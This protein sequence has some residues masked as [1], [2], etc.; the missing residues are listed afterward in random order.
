MTENSAER[1]G[2]NIN[3]NKQDF[4]TPKLRN[5]LFGDE[6]SKKKLEDISTIVMGQSPSSSNYSN[7]SDE[8]VL[9]QGNQDLQNGYIIPRIYTSQIT[10]LSKPGD[11]I[12]T[13]RAPVGDIAINEYISCI[14]R[15]VCSITPKEDKKFIYY[16]LQFLNNKNIWN[17]YSQGSTFESVNSKDIKNL[18]INIPTL[19]EQKYISEFFSLIDQKI[20]FMEKKYNVLDK[21]H[22]S[23]I[24]A[25]LNN[26][27]NNEEYKKISL[28]HIVNYTSSNLSLN[29]LEDNCGS[30]PLFG[31]DGFVKNIDF[32][33]MGEEYIGIVKDGAGVGRISYN[34]KKTSVLGT[35][36]Y[37]T[38]KGNINLKYVYYYLNMLNLSKYIVGSTI[39]HIY[40]KDYSKEK[41]NLPQLIEQEKIVN[42]LDSVNELIINLNKEIEI[43]RDFKKSLLTKMFC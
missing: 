33:E 8:T 27:M 41:I 17:K 28:N 42:L 15:G 20:S 16:Y 1:S 43:N 6:W 34:N 38:S 12:L 7:N 18:K 39:P 5:E 2:K 14:G 13:V 21:Y 32:Y 25:L 35:M 24:Y 10:K 22:K 3:V 36:G 30:Y 29:N 19:N 4:L 31:A 40:F 37:L 26:N 11:I 9:I 23:L